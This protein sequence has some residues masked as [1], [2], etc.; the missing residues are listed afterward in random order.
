[1]DPTVPAILDEL[2]RAGDPVVLLPDVDPASVRPEVHVVR[3]DPTQPTA[4]RKAR[5][6]APS[7]FLSPEPPTVT[8]S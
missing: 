7:R 1:M 4:M 3:G 2:V 5:P 8:F 6:Q